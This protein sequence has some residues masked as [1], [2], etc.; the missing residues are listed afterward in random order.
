MS[1]QKRDVQVVLDKLESTIKSVDTLNE[2]KGARELSIA[3]THLQTA[4]L[5]LKKL[6]GGLAE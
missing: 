2:I 5:W 3:I 1:Y 6:Q 4:E